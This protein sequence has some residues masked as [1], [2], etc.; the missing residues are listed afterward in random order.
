MSDPKHRVAIIG[1]GRLGQHY[2]EIYSALPN[3]Q[4]V[5]IVEANPERRDVVGPRF[6]VKAV[7]SDVTEMLNDDVPD[8]AVVVTPTKYM[9]ECVIACAE[10]GVK[11]VS[12]DKPI[13][14]RLSDADEMVQ[15][16]ADRNVVFAGGNLQRAMSE[17]QEAA[18]RI[19]AGEFG[20]LTGASLHGFGNEISGGGCQAVSVLRLFTDAEVEE[21]IAWGGPDDALEQDTDEG[22]FINGR[23]TMTTGLQCPV[24][25][26]LLTERNHGVSVW[27]DD[28]LIEWGWGPPSIHQGFD[29]GGA[30]IEIDPKYTPVEVIGLNYM[31]T[32][33][34]SFLA[35][36][37]T[38]S[39]LWISGHDLRQALEVAIAS[40]LSVQRRSAPVSLPLAD[41]SLC[42]Y[43]RAY[44]WLGGDETGKKQT[45]EEAKTYGYNNR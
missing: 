8:L 41:R 29:A 13:A 28:A 27:T 9:K 11:G 23:F 3:T 15:V 42:L 25:S 5:S 36:V 20:E 18:A 26:K 6:G 19:H 40:K 1:C 33:I 12:T 39:K 37:E 4:I 35:A 14:A 44:R 10:A 7:Y 22:L 2:A 34:R 32:S 38:G 16:C 24:Y 30:R 43:P 21:V 31:F 17:V 45:A